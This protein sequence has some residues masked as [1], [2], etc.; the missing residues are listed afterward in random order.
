MVLSVPR[1]LPPSQEREQFGQEHDAKFDVV[2]G[3]E[4]AVALNQMHERRAVRASAA[5]GARVDAGGVDAASFSDEEFERATAQE[6]LPAQNID[7][8]VDLTGGEDRAGSSP[9]EETRA[10]AALRA[11]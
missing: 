6:A 11:R 1:P 4:E 2:L 5:G 10:S 7:Q 9:G 8:E 3:P